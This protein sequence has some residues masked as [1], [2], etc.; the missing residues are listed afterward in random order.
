[1]SVAFQT[2]YAGSIPVAR[3]SDQRICGSRRSSEIAR[4]TNLRRND[5]AVVLPRG[6]LQVRLHAGQEPL[7]KKR[8]TLTKTIPVGPD[9]KSG[10]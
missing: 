8:Y 5:L 6:A 2:G 9:L 1:L 10:R 4:D 7:S 3:S